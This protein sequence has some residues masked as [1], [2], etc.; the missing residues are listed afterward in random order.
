MID[1]S[2]IF[3][4][5]NRTKLNELKEKW[6]SETKTQKLTFSV[7]IV[8]FLPTYLLHYLYYC[9]YHRH[10][11]INRRM[12]HKKILLHNSAEIIQQ[13]KHSFKTKT[14]ITKTNQNWRITISCQNSNVELIDTFV[15]T[16][17]WPVTCL[18]K[19]YVS[20]TAVQVE[21]KSQF[22]QRFRANS[23]TFSTIYLSV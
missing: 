13:F 18:V 1:K 10:M 22:L 15:W 9:S 7:S 20:E 12:K 19:A 8:A 14:K 23:Q 2:K 11:I 4:A 21:L 3:S 6:K 5:E 16:V 17:R